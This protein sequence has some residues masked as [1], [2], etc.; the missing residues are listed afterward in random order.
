MVVKK[1]VT[2]VC[3]LILVVCIFI[4]ITD[5]KNDDSTLN[6]V[7]IY[8]QSNG[9]Y[10]SVCDPLIVD[11]DYNKIPS[12]NLYYYGTK[13]GP[14][15]YNS[16]NYDKTFSSYDLFPIWADNEWKIGGYEP[17]LSNELSNRSDRDTLVINT[18]IP[19]FKLTDLEPNS[20]GWAFCYDSIMDALAKVDGYSSIE[21]VG[22]IW[23]QGE[24]DFGRDI[25]NYT[26]GFDRLLD[27]FAK[28]D[29]TSCYVVG[30]RD[31][32]GG[33]S[34]TALRQIA[35]SNRNVTFVTDIAETF[36][37]EN[38]LLRPN[39]PLHFSQK[40]R[41]VIAKILGDEI[42]ISKFGNVPNPVLTIVQILPIFALIGIL[43]G[44]GFY[45][46]NRRT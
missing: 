11:E 25:A 6:V 35:T 37:E 31:S 36:T 21:M 10:W 24:S 45:I 1:I 2:V 29:L 20:R 14:I 16:G 42:P 38:G 33:N 26:Y 18:S 41:D 8:G 7:V 28:L 5:I 4:P 34:Q 32:Y 22:W 30:V 27:G 13:D 12:H 40:G 17:I 44:I 19:G 39:D 9:A 46:Y 23:I 3:A 15:Q 43:V